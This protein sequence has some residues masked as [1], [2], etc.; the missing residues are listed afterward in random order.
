MGRVW[1]RDW[2]MLLS[3]WTLGNWRAY[4]LN[5]GSTAA[6]TFR[7]YTETSI[8]ICLVKSMFLRSIVKPSTVSKQVASLSGMR[9]RHLKRVNLGISCSSSAASIYHMPCVCLGI[10]NALCILSE[11]AWNYQKSGIGSVNFLRTNPVIFYTS[12]FGPNTSTAFMIA[13]TAVQ[14][15]HRLKNLAYLG[16]INGRG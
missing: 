12:I 7:L 15:L 11:W 10:H 1:Q 6:T 8:K 16:A 4:L 14:T 13:T 5:G 2:G 9:N 3:Q